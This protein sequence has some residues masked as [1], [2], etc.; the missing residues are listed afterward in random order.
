MRATIA[1]AQQ[2]ISLFHGDCMNNINRR[3]T[4]TEA[5]ELRQFDEFIGERRIDN[6]RGELFLCEREQI[7]A[8]LTL[9]EREGFV[10]Q[11][12]LQ[13]LNADSVGEVFLKRT[14]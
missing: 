5:K 14:P 1:L 12:T 8:A 9:F 6:W 11:G 4:T 7:H 10:Q 13:G 3:A 2:H